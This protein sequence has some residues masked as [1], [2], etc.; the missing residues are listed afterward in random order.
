MPNTTLQAARAAKNDE[1]YTQF[2]DIEREVEAYVQYN[3]DVFRGKTVLLPCDDPDCSN[4]TRYFAQNFERLGL[5]KLIST[6]YAIESKQYKIG[7]QTSL[8]E[9]QSPQYD[10]DKSKTNGKIFILDSDRTGDGRIDLDDLQ[11][12]YLH[13]DG[14]FRSDEVKSLRDEAD[15]IIT[16]PPFSLFRDFFAWIMEAG[17]EFLIIGNMSAISYKEFFPFIMENK[18]WLGVSS[19]AK[20]YIKPEGGVQKMGNTCWFTNIDHGHR[21]QPLQLM[22][23]EDNRRYTQHKNDRR[24]SFA[25]LQYDNYFAIKIPFVDAIPNDYE[26]V[27]AVPLSFLQ[28]YCPTQFEIVGITDR[29]NRYGLKSKEYTKEETPKYSDL[30]RRGVIKQNNQYISGFAE[31]LIRKRK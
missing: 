19:G 24:W 11:W 31:L 18:V 27:M 1:F 2:Y 10:P 9:E 21:H 12:K 23:M 29:G 17:K 14:D 13:D 4:F 28:K 30:N 22:T 25:Y 20:E 8:L 26:G 7:L 15:V 3:Q 6:S 16:N 5:K